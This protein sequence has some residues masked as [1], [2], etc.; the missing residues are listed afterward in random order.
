MDL[1]ICAI[2]PTVIAQALHNDQ[3]RLGSLHPTRDFNYVTDTVNGFQKAVSL[4]R[5]IGEVI[6]LGTGREVSIL[7]LCEIVQ[8]LVGR[9]LPIDKEK[10]RVRP[11]ASEVERLIC[12]NLKARQMLEWQ[13][14]VTL[15]EGLQKTIEWVKRNSG[16]RQT[17]EY[18]I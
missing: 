9:E 2:I 13:P 14:R 3:I 5:T 16:Q 1:A 15:E 10:R 11:A 6:N 7:Q 8:Q 17:V 12:N 18:V 4:E